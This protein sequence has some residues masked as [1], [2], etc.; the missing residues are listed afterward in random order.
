MNLHD[1]LPPDALDGVTIAVSISD[2]P[3]LGTLGLTEHHVRL[4]LGEMAR[5]VLRARGRLIYGGALRSGNYTDFL[6]E[7]NDRYGHPDSLVITLPWHEHRR[8]PLSAIER[9]QRAVSSRGRVLCLSPDGEQVAPGQG[10]GEGPEADDGSVSRADSLSA[11]RRSVTAEADARVVVGGRLDDYQ[12]RMPGIVEEALVSIEHG[13]PLYVVGGFGGAAAL[14]A[15]AVGLDNQEWAPPTWADRAS[16]T[17]LSRAVEA[18]QAAVAT[19]GLADNRLDS[20]ER[21]MLSATPRPSEVA[22]L[23]ARGLGRLNDTGP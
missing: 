9:T 6:I 17:E 20:Q 2:S 23:V 11:M 13:Q 10:R 19:H 18:L 16:R 1:L 22:S 5:V 7:E 21:L 3:D 12:G 8:V 15:R 4:T 14:V